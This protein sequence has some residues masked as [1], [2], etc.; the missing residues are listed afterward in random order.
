MT[1]TNSYCG[2][3][4]SGLAC[5][6]DRQPDLLQADP[7]L[8]NSLLQK[9]IRRGDAELAQRA[10]L[11]FLNQKGTALWRR[12]MIIACEDI[13]A[14]SVD[15]IKSAAVACSDAAWRRRAGGD[16]AAAMDLT[17]L[18][19]DSD[20]SRSA[21]HLITTSKFHPAFS[22]RKRAAERLSA[23]EN[24]HVLSDESSPLLNRAWAALELSGLK[25]SQARIAAS[26]PDLLNAYLVLGAPGE[27]VNAVEIIATRI[28]EPMAV[29][30]PLVWLKARR[31][32]AFPVL[33]KELPRCPTVAD[34]P[35]YALDKHTLSGRTAIRNLVRNNQG[36]QACLDRYVEPSR[37]HDAA[38]M[39]AFYVDAA[40][41]AQK[42]QWS[43]G[44]E[45]EHL[46]TEADLM[47]VGV[48]IEG[49]APILDIF[50]RSIDQLNEFRSDILRKRRPVAA[51]EV[52]FVAGAAR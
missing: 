39:A 13:G 27:L 44:D 7:W 22:T 29:L 49:V 2:N 11:T 18:L 32:G 35:M 17:Q 21:E 24:F 12:L 30:A 31:E 26:F 51:A 25:T 9:A 23:A 8:V 19:A 40:P 28:R 41:L 4:N 38:Y 42:F 1:D 5:E 20:K 15:V 47:K 45:L 6:S 33:L 36:V 46:G 16:I 10:A 50:A 14:A 43:Q 52:G 34:I 37:W 48:P 3:H